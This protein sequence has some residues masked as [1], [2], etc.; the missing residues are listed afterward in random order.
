MAVKYY[1]GVKDNVEKSFKSKDWTIPEKCTIRAL[2]D[3]IWAGRYDL[4]KTLE[5]SCGENEL[6]TKDLEVIKGEFERSKEVVVNGFEQVMDYL[7]NI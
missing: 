1:T 4:F 2:Q 3:K 7:I 6:L 5:K